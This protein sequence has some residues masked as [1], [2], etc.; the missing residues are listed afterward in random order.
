MPSS[1]ILEGSQSVVVNI[2]V[3][4]NILNQNQGQYT[5]TI[6]ITSNDPDNPTVTV[7][8]TLTA[9]CVLVKPNPYD[10]TKGN[11]TFFGDGIVPGQTT[12]KIYTLNG[13][14]VRKIGT[15]SIF[16]GKNMEAV[17]NF[18]WDG[19]NENGE[20]V[21]SGIYLYSFTTSSGFSQSKKLVLLK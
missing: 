19:T 7:D 16:S 11:L 20:Q 1:L 13:E 18:S 15:A 10:P 14:L 21:T 5:G 12:I 17:P 8:V 9:T 6:T 3:D 4:N 2:T